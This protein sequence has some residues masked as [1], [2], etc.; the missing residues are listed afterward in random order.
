MATTHSPSTGP[1]MNQGSCEWSM[2]RKVL[3]EATLSGRP[4]RP[5]RRVDRTVPLGGDL[6]RRRALLYQ[7][8]VGRGHRRLVAGAFCDAAE[9]LVA[10]DLQV[11]EGERER[12]Q[13]ARRV[14]LS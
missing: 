11:L 6:R 8:L 12:R 14:R 13:L 4:H 7:D 9:L 1:P 5:Q 3:P 2:A 10:A